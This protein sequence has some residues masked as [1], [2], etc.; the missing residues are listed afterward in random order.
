MILSVSIHGKYFE[1]ETRQKAYSKQTKSIAFNV[2][3]TAF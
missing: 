3:H 1:E 2:T